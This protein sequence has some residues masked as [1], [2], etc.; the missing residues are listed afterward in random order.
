VPNPDGRLKPGM[1]ARIDIE[2]YAASG[3]L[4][5]S[6]DALVDL[7][8]TLGVYVVDEEQVARLVPVQIHFISGNDVALA[9]GLEEGDQVITEGKGSVREGTE[10]RLV[11]GD[12]RTA[13]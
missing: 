7:G 10:V 6:A 3:G 4:V 1:F 12:L 9:A 11:F 13:S 8:G 5:I 2:R